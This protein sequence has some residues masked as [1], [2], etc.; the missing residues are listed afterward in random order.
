MSTTETEDTTERT[1]PA[2][3][4][5]AA[6]PAGPSPLRDRLVLPLVMPIVV[7]A[8]VVTVAINISRILIAGGE[9]DISLIVGIVLTVGILGGAAA[10]SASPRM[11]GSSLAWVLGGSL[12][13]IMTAGVIT[14]S[15]SEE[16]GEGEA[17][18]YEEPAGEPVATL[19][20]DALP[21]NMFQSDQF[22]TLAGVIEIEYVQ[23]G[24][25]HTLV[26]EESEFAGF[27]LAVP[28]G[29]T[30]GKVDLRPGD[31]TIYCTVPG[32]REAGMEAG[33]T[34]REG[35]G[36]GGQPTPGQPP[37]APAPQD[38]PTT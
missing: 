8:I 23:V 24:G 16:H 19:E 11:R 33:L 5:P 30:T 9:S 29:P 38:P 18:G 12:A 15:G 17:S 31:Y 7:I 2:A 21:T 22:A 14:L 35:P 37:P 10:V 13:V 27:Q 26:F 6:L 34:A 4:E 20:V 36:G 1:A 28:D 25:S 3:D 32:H